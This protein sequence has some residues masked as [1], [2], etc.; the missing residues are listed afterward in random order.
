MA[1][2]VKLLDARLAGV[3]GLAFHNG[4]GQPPYTLETRGGYTLGGGAAGLN[5]VNIQISNDNINWQRGIGLVGGE[6][7]TEATTAVQELVDLP[8]LSVV[9]IQ[10][11]HKYIR[12]TTGSSMVGSATV[13]LQH[14]R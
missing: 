12:A 2:R 5:G 10:Q 14:P 1:S 8:N 7:F 3:T 13:V 9:A 4:M 6:N 11:Y